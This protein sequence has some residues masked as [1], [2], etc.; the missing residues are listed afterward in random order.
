[1]KRVIALKYEIKKTEVNFKGFLIPLKNKLIIKKYLAT[2]L[3][4]K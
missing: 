2:V 1:M 3:L 4:N